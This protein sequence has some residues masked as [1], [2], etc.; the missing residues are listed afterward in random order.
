MEHIFIPQAVQNFPRLSAGEISFVLYSQS[1]NHSKNR[2]I[3][4]CNA[5]SFVLSGKKEIYHTSERTVVSPGEATLIPEG[6]SLIAERTFDNTPYSSLVAF[7]PTAFA[8]KFLQQKKLTHAA[9]SSTS[10]QLKFQQ[11]PYVKDFIRSICT[12]ITDHITVP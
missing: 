4:N 1:N 7:F 8:I 11:T 10:D 9:V 12:L 6:N 3:F 2:V 5:V